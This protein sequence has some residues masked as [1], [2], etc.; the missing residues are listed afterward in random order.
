MTSIF[1]FPKV[2]DVYEAG[3]VAHWITT[4]YPV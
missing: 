4:D 1:T 2:L 3:M